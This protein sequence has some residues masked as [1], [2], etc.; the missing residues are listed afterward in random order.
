MQISAF[1]YVHVI[2]LYLHNI[3]KIRVMQP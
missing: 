3:P 2:R 1:F